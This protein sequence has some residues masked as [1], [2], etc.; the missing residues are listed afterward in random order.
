MPALNL[1]DISIT[2]GL[3]NE[4]KL[5]QLSILADEESEPTIH[6]VAEEQVM[7]A[8]ESHSL[9]TL[10]SIIKY[11]YYYSNGLRTECF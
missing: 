4:Q 7:P 2:A 5:M 3:T 1:I 9:L 10:L 8:L 11:T 6:V